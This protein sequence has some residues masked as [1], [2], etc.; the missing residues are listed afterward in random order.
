MINPVYDVV[1][2]CL[3]LDGS[4]A[5]RITYRNMR[6]GGARKMGFQRIGV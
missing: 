1:G 3:A 6:S 4:I 2:F 5:A